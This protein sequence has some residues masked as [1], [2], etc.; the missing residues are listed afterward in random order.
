MRQ[1]KE[2]DHRETGVYI[3]TTFLLPE[4]QQIL[5][6]TGLENKIV[7]S[8]PQEGGFMTISVNDLSPRELLNPNTN[9]IIT[10]SGWLYADGN[11][12]VED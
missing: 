10:G 11:R 6:K 2:K 12:V 3:S 8:Q 1:T 5:R 7:F 9:F 4:R